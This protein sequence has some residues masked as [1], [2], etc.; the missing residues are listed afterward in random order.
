MA[1][2]NYEF[3]NLKDLLVRELKDLYDAEKQLTETLPE[4]AQAANS[5][6]LKQAFQDH[7]RETQTHVT[8][9]EEIFRGLNQPVRGE[10]CPAMK[11]IIKEGSSMISAKGDPSVRDAGLIAAAQRAEHY[12]MA[13]YGSARSFARQLG[14]NDLAE[15]LQKTLEEEGNAD[16]KLTA[17]A[18]AGVNQM[19]GA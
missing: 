7:Y 4:M 18:E 16:K 19:A 15:I 12:E 17:I 8:R 3:G 5:S 13:V 10:S 1:L 9:L 11:G 6:E 14:R 2:F